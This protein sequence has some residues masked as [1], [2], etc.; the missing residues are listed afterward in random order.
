MY[1]TINDARAI[2]S[3]QWIY[4]AL[5]DLISKKKY[6][7]IKITDLIKKAGVGRS[8]FYR[9]YDVIDD[10]IMEK[11]DS[12]FYDFY[13]FIFNSDFKA[14]TDISPKLFIPFF[15][16]W[17]TRSDILELIIKADKINLLNKR[18]KQ[19]VGVIIE[20]YEIF[21]NFTE[22]DNEYATEIMVGVLSSVLVKWIKD[23]K[24]VSTKKLADTLIRTLFT[25][26]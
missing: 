1:K 21:S 22:T 3:K 10:V 16:Y 20:T 8:T 14:E 5:V 19:S 11:L 26:R 18:L 24:K 9:N 6:D 17:D 7:D 25:V 23:E 12:T 15:S 4:E 13:T 2:R